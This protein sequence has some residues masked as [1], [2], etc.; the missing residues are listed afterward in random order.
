MLLNTSPCEVAISKVLFK[1]GVLHW[2][3][4][5]LIGLESPQ[6]LPDCLPA[7]GIAGMLPL[8]AL[9]LWVLVTEYRFLLYHGQH[10]TNWDLF[11]APL[12]VLISLSSQ[13]ICVALLLEDRHSH[14]PAKH[15]DRTV[16]VLS[17]PLSVRTMAAT[18]QRI[19][20][21]PSCHKWQCKKGKQ[22]DGNWARRKEGKDA[23]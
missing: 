22:V 1:D 12:L 21:M 13:L 4:S 9:F 14:K 18:K 17:E 6:D 20:S 8:L 15:T 10:F 2:P 3:W 23:L 11:P 5:W 16:S 19:S 7:A